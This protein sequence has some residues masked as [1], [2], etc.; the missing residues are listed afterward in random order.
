LINVTRHFGIR[1]YEINHFIHNVWYQEYDSG[2]ETITVLANGIASD[3]V[4]HVFEFE[5][6]LFQG[7]PA[8]DDAVFDTDFVT[9]ACSQFFERQGGARPIGQ[10]VWIVTSGVARLGME[11]IDTNGHY[12]TIPFTEHFLY[13][14]YTFFD[15]ADSGAYQQHIGNSEYKQPLEFA[16]VILVLISL[17]AGSMIY[18]KNKW[19]KEMVHDKYDLLEGV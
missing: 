5:I 4:S 16:A 17:A 15:L 18:V 12:Q 2:K 1:G 7:E 9:G 14:P 13:D 11:V 10:G 19:S 6:K 3:S 8:G